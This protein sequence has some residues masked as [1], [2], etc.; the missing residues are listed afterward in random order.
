MTTDDLDVAAEL[1]TRSAY[2]NPRPVTRDDIRAILWRAY[3][4]GA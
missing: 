4:G 1:A 3:D 2:P